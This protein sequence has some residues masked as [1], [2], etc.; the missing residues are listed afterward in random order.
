[1]KLR[2]R[3]KYA[4][5][6]L[7]QVPWIA[8]IAG[9]PLLRGILTKLPGVR[10]IY[11][12]GWSRL[13]PFDRMHGTDTSLTKNPW[14]L[15]LTDHPAFQHAHPYAGSQPG[16]LRAVLSMLP[17]L[18]T[19]TFVDLGCGKGRPLFV[20]A[21]FPFRDIVG[22][23]F[24]PRLAEV[25]RKNAARMAELFP[26]RTRVRI[27]VGDATAYNFPDGDLV[28][29][30]YSPFAE[31]I[32]REVAASL[33]RALVARER[34]VYVIYCNPLFGYCFDAIP[35]LS[36]IFTRVI[37]HQEDEQGFGP[38]TGDEVA[39]WRGGTAPLFLE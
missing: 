4:I 29:F 17:D 22:V 25:A 28:L 21:E 38:G 33:N 34:S 1:M 32:M 20:A 6:E 19:S 5:C 3:A 24:S 16:P 35:S 12:T 27:E 10:A 30:L 8:K 31:P 14:E 39:L 23:E 15:N 2:Q 7:G 36:R 18:A 26:K 37:P 13:H 11:E 9:V